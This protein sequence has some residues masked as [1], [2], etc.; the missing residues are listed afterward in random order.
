M[1]KRALDDEALVRKEANFRYIKRR[2]LGVI[3]KLAELGVDFDN[4]EEMDLTELTDYF[5]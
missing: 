3:A 2:N 1:K 5:K 4:Y